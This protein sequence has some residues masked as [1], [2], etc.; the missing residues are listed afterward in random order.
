MHY[1]G[2]LGG[3]TNASFE[4]TSGQKQRARTMAL[5]GCGLLLIA[6]LASVFP[7]LGSVSYGA[8][9]YLLLG[10]TLVSTLGIICLSVMQHAQ[11]N[12]YWPNLRSYKD[13]DERQVRERLIIIQK[14]YVY[15]TILLIVFLCLAV[16]YGDTLVRTAGDMMRGN[17][18]LNTSWQALINTL[19][20]VIWMPGIVAAFSKR[21]NA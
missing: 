12:L 18:T 16:L 14:A 17:G 2:C 5:A 8:E 6:S 7:Y 3:A 21:H 4:V 1:C 11:A 19:V 15:S 10:A 9:R 20:A 13:L